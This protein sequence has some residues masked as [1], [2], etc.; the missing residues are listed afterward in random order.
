MAGDL[1]I[2]HIRRVPL[3]PNIIVLQ[4]PRRVEVVHKWRGRA[5][6]LAGRQP[7]F[8]GI[9][10]RASVRAREV[11]GA[12]E[13]LVYVPDLGDEGGTLDVGVAGLPEAVPESLL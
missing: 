8:Q 4:D 13:V 1:D 9:A 5:V 7:P 2:P 3:R 10:G 6:E 11:R 12:V